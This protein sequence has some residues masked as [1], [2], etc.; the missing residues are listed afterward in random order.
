MIHMGGRVSTAPPSRPLA[1]PRAPKRACS[2]QGAARLSCSARMPRPKLPPA[3]ARALPIAA[4]PERICPALWAELVTDLGIRGAGSMIAAIEERGLVQ[5]TG[6]DFTW[7]APERADAA[8]DLDRRDP[9]AWRSAHLV[10]ARFFAR[11]GAEGD[12]AAAVAH[13]VAVGDRP[14]AEALLRARGPDVAARGRARSFLDAI[15]RL[16]GGDA[17]AP[18]WLAYL[19]ARAHERAGDLSASLDAYERSIASG[20]GPEAP[21]WMPSPATICGFAGRVA[22]RVGQIDRAERLLARARLLAGEELPAA[23]WHLAA[24]LRLARGDLAGAAEGFDRAARAAAEDRDPAEQAEAL[25]GLGVIAMREGS[26]LRAVERYR[27]ALIVSLG[28]PGEERTARIRANLATALA[29]TGHPE[30]VP[31]FAEAARERERLGDL[32]GAANSTAAG[33]SAREGTGDPEGALADLARARRL[34]EMGGDPALLLEIRLLR[35]GLSVRLGQGAAGASELRAAEE[36][37]AGIERPDP[38]LD[39]MLDEAR[40]EVASA[41]RAHAAAACLARRA[42]RRFERHRAHYLVARVD[43][44]LARNAAAAGRPRAALAHLAALSRRAAP[45]GYRFPGEWAAVRALEIGAGRGDALTSAH[46]RA[47]LLAV[48]R[49]PAA[50]SDPAA[51]AYRIVDRR[52]ARVAGEDEV[53]RLRA[54]GKALLVDLVRQRILRPSGEVPLSGQ[55]VLVPLLLALLGKPDRAFEAP[56]LHREVWG[57]DRFDESARTRVKVALSRLRALVGP[58]VLESRSVVS[59]TGVA[60]KVF[61]IAAG[62]DFAI[63]ERG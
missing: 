3:L 18:P 29:I 10:C 24:R 62:L 22:A 49:G 5:R 26:A 54:S 52:G 1:A 17:A 19:A 48:A 31:A 46:C 37:R 33:A 58:G 7:G 12:L 38:L 8:G 41:R 44:L 61:A 57:S 4:V 14:S 32:A 59:P 28:E 21:P 45:S 63:I 2:G 35:S 36:L 47:L 40:A 60:R 20:A 34:A 6:D 56:H 15:D 25:S 13:L 42:R 43:L 51:G 39:G 50:G 53:E 9:T 30:A 55:R 23:A 27:R 11:R 16:R